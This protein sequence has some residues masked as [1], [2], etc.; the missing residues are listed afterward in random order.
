M[1]NK[2]SP[3]E[4]EL[5]YKFN[6][7]DLLEEALSHPSLKQHPNSGVKN[8]ER[9]EFLGDSILGFIITEILFKK[10]ADYSEGHLAKIKS[11]LVSSQIISEIAKTIKL[12]QHIIIT[13][14]EELSGGRTNLNNLENS[15]EAIIAAIYLDS[16][17]HSSYK[18]VET[19]WDKYL[20][21]IDLSIADPKTSLQEWSQSMKYSTPEYTVIERSGAAHN[22]VFT[23]KITIGPH[24]QIGSGKSIK[25]AEKDAAKKLLGRISLK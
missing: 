4:K 11:Y 8:Y 3:L 21:N 17:I 9:L 20:H 25:T 16:D 12:D 5:N 14:G 15:L 22:P 7:I 6:N 10:F 19:L 18:I 24:T 1:T 23:V 2:F 13:K